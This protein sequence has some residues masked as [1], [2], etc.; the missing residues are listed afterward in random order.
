MRA[1]EGAPITTQYVSPD[2]W[3]IIRAAGIPDRRGGDVVWPWICLAPPQQ[4]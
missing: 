4:S 3:P 1:A 2:A